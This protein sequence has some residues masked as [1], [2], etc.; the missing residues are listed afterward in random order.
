MFKVHEV[1]PDSPR[2]VILQ[3]YRNGVPVAVT[4]R[5]Q[6]GQWTGL[7]SGANLNDGVPLSEQAIWFE[8]LLPELPGSKTTCSDLVKIRP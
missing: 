2:V 3:D 6:N 8:T 7:T 1:K 5:Y 4:C